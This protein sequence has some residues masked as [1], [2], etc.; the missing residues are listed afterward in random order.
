MTQPDV[1]AEASHTNVLEG[2]AFL[3]RNA[4]TN[5]G[6][7]EVS[8]GGELMLLVVTQVQQLRDTNPHPGSIAIGTNGTG[9]GYTAADLYRI[10]GHPLVSDNVRMIIDPST[11]PLSKRVQ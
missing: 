11:I 3:V 5:V 7:T 4:V 6:A 9:E 2:R 1:R 8:A 10:D